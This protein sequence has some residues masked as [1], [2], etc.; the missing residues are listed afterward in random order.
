MSMFEV[1]NLAAGYPGR[2]VIQDVS[3]TLEP[4]TVTGLLG[5]NGSGKTTLIRAICGILPHTG[6]C[7]LEGETLEGLSPRKLARLCGYIPQRSGLAIRISVLD[8]VLM[9]FNPRLGLLEQP[10]A[11]MERAAHAALGQVGLED[12]AGEDFLTLSEG[13]RQRVLLARALVC[14]GRLLLMDEPESALDFPHRYQLLELLRRWAAQEG[15]GV[16]AALHDP[17]L[18]L[19]GCH[20]LLLLKDGRILAA[21][22]PA[23]DKLDDMERALAQIYGPVELLRC[24]R[25]RGGEQLV[26]LRKEEER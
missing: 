6:R 4:G 23:E 24:R 7:V 9:G 10:G 19:N 13:Q 15:R 1:K 22:R 5:A 2:E 8:V 25:R 12:R 16:L 3:F 26:M 11:A 14:G 21:L 17:A 20:Q 18:A